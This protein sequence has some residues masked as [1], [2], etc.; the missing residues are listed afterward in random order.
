V[1]LGHT[2]GAW[3]LEKRFTN[4]R[5]FDWTAR[6]LLFASDQG[7]TR[8]DRRKVELVAPG[9]VPTDARFS[10]DGRYVGYRS[11]AGKLEVYDLDARKVVLT[12]KWRPYLAF[13]GKHVTTMSDGEL[14]RGDLE[15]GTSRVLHDFGSAAETVKIPFF[16]GT[17]T[18]TSYDYALSPDGT[19]LYLIKQGEARVITIGNP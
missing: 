17:T 9:L 8:Y 1:V 6:G 16:G 7:I 13:H 11:A 10:R 19:L 18:N 5:A 15:A 14:W 12:S 4:L 2:P 3:Q